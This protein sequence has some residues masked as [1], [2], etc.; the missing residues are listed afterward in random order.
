[1]RQRE[2]AFAAKFYRYGW[3]DSSEYL[4]NGTDINKQ[5]TY[6]EYL[7]Y[8]TINYSC[9][10]FFFFTQRKTAL[11]SPLRLIMWSRLLAI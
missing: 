9:V 7:E 10:F 2:Y 1:M 4:L 5:I 8:M 11:V 3:T 6:G